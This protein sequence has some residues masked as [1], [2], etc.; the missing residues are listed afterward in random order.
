[1][2]PDKLNFIEAAS[3]LYSGLTAWS[4]LYLSGELCIRDPKN[5]RVL[6]T[7]ASGGVGTLAIQMLN[8]SGANVIASCN[9]TAINLVKKLGAHS[10]HDYRDPNY[11]TNVAKDGPFDIILDCANMGYKKIPPS[12]QYSKFIT[13]NSPLIKNTD[14]YGLLGGMA[15]SARD[16]MVANIPKCAQGKT[17]RWGFFAPFHAGVEFIDDLINKDKVIDLVFS[18]NFNDKIFHCY[19]Y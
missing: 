7:G 18:F 9:S 8:A 5:Y 4:A 3:I 16:L 12:W 14:K 10:A 15:A 6:V 2:K 13:L 11:I 1:M 19:S 17:V